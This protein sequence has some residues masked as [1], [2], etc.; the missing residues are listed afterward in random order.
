M[1][2]PVSCEARLHVLA[3]AADGERELVVR[4]HNLDA[5]GILVEH[6]L[7]DLGGLQRIDD[8]GRGVGRPGDDVDLLALE[9]VHDRL[10]ARAAHADAGARPGRS[11][12]RAT[13]TPILAREPGSRA[14][15]FT[16]MMPS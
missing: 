2:Q 13:T 3:A 1:S 16:S 14:T 7:H 15:A 9:L 11:R 12:N 4:H 6:H 5:R 10:D 8:E